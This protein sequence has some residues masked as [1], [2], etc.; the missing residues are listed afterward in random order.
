MTLAK[1]AMQTPS[2]IVGFTRLSEI[3]ELRFSALG[4]RSGSTVTKLLKT[5]LQDP[6]EC[7]VDSQL[8]ALDAWLLNHILVEPR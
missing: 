4:L 7:L 8:L 1:L 6:V 5:P 2:R 3:D